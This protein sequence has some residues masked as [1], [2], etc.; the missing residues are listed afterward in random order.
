MDASAPPA[1]K[2]RRWKTSSAL[3]ITAG[4]APP[5]EGRAH[6][7]PVPHPPPPPF[8]NWAAE[9]PRPPRRPLNGGDEKRRPPCRL[10]PAP[11]RRQRPPGA[12]ERLGPAV[13]LPEVRWRRVQ[14]VRLGHGPLR[15]L[16]LAD[17]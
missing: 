14:A 15:A 12:G 1:V 2:W 8:R 4:A 17:A 6:P 10:P 9:G 7:P 13:L 5:A 11:R 16:R 3:P